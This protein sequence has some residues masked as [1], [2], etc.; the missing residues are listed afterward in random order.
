MTNGS[1]PT[2]LDSVDV[3]GSLNPCMDRRSIEK[4][5]LLGIR[6]FFAKLV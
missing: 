6:F 2:V 1:D 5:T 4:P 3:K